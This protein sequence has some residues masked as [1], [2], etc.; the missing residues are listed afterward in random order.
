MTRRSPN[1]WGLK[2]SPEWETFLFEHRCALPSAKLV[3][4]VASL[5][6]KAHRYGS[7][8]LNGLSK[9][10]VKRQLKRAA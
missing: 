3:Q 10:A 2:L 1:E 5:K 8:S 6:M 4:H 9:H 7:D